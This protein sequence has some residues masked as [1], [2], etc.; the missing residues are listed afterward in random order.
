M[1]L[2]NDAIRKIEETLMSQRCCSEVTA[3]ETHY[4]RALFCPPHHQIFWK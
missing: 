4:L 3:M 1:M 2:K